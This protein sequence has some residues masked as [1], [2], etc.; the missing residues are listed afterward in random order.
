MVCCLT[1]GSDAVGPLDHGLKPTDRGPAWTFLLTLIVI[2]HLSQEWGVHAIA[3]PSLLKT[4]FECLHQ[5]WAKSSNNEVL[6]TPY[7][8]FRAFLKVKKENGWMK[9]VLY[10]GKLKKVK[11]LP[12]SLGSFV[13][14]TKTYVL[15]YSN[16]TKYSGSWQDK[17]NHKS[18]IIYASINLSIYYKLKST[19]SWRNY[20]NNRKYTVMDEENISILHLFGFWKIIFLFDAIWIS[21]QILESAC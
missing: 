21:L 18:T 5:G 16:W 3:L 11:L 13:L 12:L 14:E 4:S 19:K 10:Y 6:K 20:I 1:T 2:T 15:Q 7:N 9:A 8:L 17:N